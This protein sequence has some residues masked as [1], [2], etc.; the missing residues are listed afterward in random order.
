MITDEDASLENDAF[1]PLR[2]EAEQMKLLC[3]T[4]SRTPFMGS[5]RSYPEDAREFSPLEP[6]RSNPIDR[7]QLPKSVT[8]IFSDCMRPS[9]DR[10][11]WQIPSAKDI[12]PDYQSTTSQPSHPSLQHETR[13]QNGKHRSKRVKIEQPMGSFLF[14]SRSR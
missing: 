5:N 9:S 11:Q 8:E 12:S 6:R 1:S 10:D 2:R 3:E 14:F 7:Y 13:G 4:L